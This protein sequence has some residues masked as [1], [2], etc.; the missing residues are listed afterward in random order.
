MSCIR[1]RF[2]LSVPSHNRYLMLG[3]HCSQERKGKIRKV[4]GFSKVTQHTAAG[5]NWTPGLPN[6]STAWKPPGKALPEEEPGPV[7]YPSH[8]TL[9]KGPGPQGK[10]ALPC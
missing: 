5:E 9:Y 6:C 10:R 2:S 7:R 1:P 3:H 4:Y 8:L